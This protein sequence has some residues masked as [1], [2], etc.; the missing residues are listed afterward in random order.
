MT[1]DIDLLDNI[2]KNFREAKFDVAKESREDAM[3]KLGDLGLPTGKHEEYRFT[4]ISKNLEKLFTWK[5]EKSLST[6]HSINQFLIEGIDANVL[7][8]INGTYST[9]HSKVICPDSQAQV[10]TISK[11]F[12]E[13]NDILNQHFNK[14]VST[15][16]AF[17]AM[18]T[19]LWQDG[20]FIHVPANVTVQK[21]FFI[22]HINDASQTQVIAHTRMLI[23]AEKGSSLS[24]IERFESQG[25]N[26]VFH[27]FT[28]E[29]AIK[30]NAHLE[31]CKI[32]NDCGNSYQ[33][34][35]TLIHQKNSSKVNTF[36]LALNGKLIRNNFGITID[37]ENC[38]SHFYGLSI[39]NGNTLADN[40]TVVDHKKPN[41]F[42][43]ELYKGIMDDN[44]KGIFNGK[45]FVRPH[46]QK[47]NAFQSN[48]NILISEAATIN[49]KPQ[50]E[51]WADDVK[52]SHGCTTG[53]LDEAAVFYLQSRGI[54]YLTAKAMLLYAFAAE[55]LEPITDEKLK[56]YLDNLISERLHKDF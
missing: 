28:E 5:S 37:G 30:E 8:F 40:H 38:E 21:P 11:A 23:V 43:N 41:S 35:N 29:F 55:V 4:P 45:I 10:K 33:V 50:L 9:T 19:A 39:L 53:Q 51:I 17:A 48:R 26:P 36:T 25:S 20:V 15:D 16:D 2:T 6:I 3:V 34:T 24:I 14:L 56:V 47:T 1:T 13:E 18:N 44:S 52:C 31:Y 22:L 46:A 32:Q 42:S 27:T 54:S 12:L 49:T 7:V